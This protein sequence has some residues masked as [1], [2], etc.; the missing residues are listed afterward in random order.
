MRSLDDLLR[1]FRQAREAMKVVVENMPRMIGVESVRAVKNNFKTESYFG[2]DKWESRSDKT[3]KAY[4]A[5]R[6]KGKQGRYNGSVFSASKP[7]LRQTLNLYNSI[8]YKA[9]G[10]RVF[11]GTNLSLIP[12]AQIQNEGGRGIPRRQYQPFGNQKPHPIMLANIKKK[13]IYERNKALATF[14]K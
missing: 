3:N 14:K 1:D 13:Y 10:K 7:L 11:I 4:M 5:G 9:L 8:Q 12:Y 6:S 2:Q